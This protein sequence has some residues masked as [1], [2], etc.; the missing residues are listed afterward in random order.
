MEALKSLNWFLSS[1]SDGGVSGEC[2]TSG[3]G[4]RPKEED[5]DMERLPEFDG[6]R[7]EG[8]DSGAL[9]SGT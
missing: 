1:S 8:L 4:V 6:D 2:R 5:G 7:T 9:L 3:E